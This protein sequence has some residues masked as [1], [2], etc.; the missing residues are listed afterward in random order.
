MK[1]SVVINAKVYILKKCKSIH[2][3]IELESKKEKIKGKELP[4]KQAQKLEDALV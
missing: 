3:Q 1:L 2:Y 4:I